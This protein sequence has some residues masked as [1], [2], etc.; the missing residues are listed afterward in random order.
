MSFKEFIEKNISRFI[1]V[2]KRIRGYFSELVSGKNFV[3]P[4]AI[5]NHKRN[6]I[7]GKGS[8]LNEY[9]II[10]SPISKFIIGEHSHLGPFTVV[11]TSKFG[12][13]LGNYVM[14]APHCVFAEGGHEYRNLN[15]PMLL[16]GEFS[17]GP[18]VV[19]DD[20][21]IG[22]NCTIL[23]NVRIGKGSIIG[24]NSVV[25]RDVEPYA[26]VAGA[27]IEVIGSRIKSR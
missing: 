2:I 1:F 18:I 11:L 12:I 16:A 5:L 6:V 8:V 3:H 22:A 27:P 10:R 7:L 20:V 4:T 9:V 24:A 23:Q 26:I 15:K 17:T 25:N 14:V 19:E 21:W 13:T